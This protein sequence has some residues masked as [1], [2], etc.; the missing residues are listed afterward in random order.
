MVSPRPWSPDTLTRLLLSVLG[1]LAVGSVVGLMADTALGLWAPEQDQ[2]TRRLLAGF[3]GTVTFHAGLLAVVGRFLRKHR[4]RWREVFGFDRPGLGR[5]IQLGLGLGVAFF[6]LNLG[7][8]Q[9]SGLLWTG[10][11]FEVQNQPTIVALQQGHSML[12]VVLI[13]IA[14]LVLAP[15]VEELLFRGLLYPWLRMVTSSRTAVTVTTV[16]FALSHMNLLGF[17]P[18]VCFGLL[19]IWLYDTTDNL[20][21]PIAAHFVFNL[22]NFTVALLMP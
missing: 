1:A 9:L 6:I 21:A 7:L 3:L 10:L 13:A 4:L 16:L 8:M 2:E 19:L 5:A 11:G 14:A 15:V 22:I 20:L 12:Q 18:L 17:L